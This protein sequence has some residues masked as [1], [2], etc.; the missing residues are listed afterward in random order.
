MSLK[1]DTNNMLEWEYE[2]LHYK[3]Y[4][5]MKKFYFD[6]ETTGLDPIKND[7]IQL[8]AIIEIDGQECDRFVIEM[9][10]FSYDNI[11][12]EALDTHGM[13]I[14]TIKTFQTCQEGY[15]KILSALDRYID[16]Y[17]KNDK[18]IVC[19]Y[20]VRFDIDFLNQF[21][22]KN[23]NDYLFS[24]FGAQQDPLPVFGYLKGNGQI[25][26]QNLKLVTMCQELGV[27]LE[28]A[29]DAM[30]DIDA[31]KRLIE[32]LNKRLIFKQNA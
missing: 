24:Y 30:A 18:F 19:G 26:P 21:F 16:K 23:G 8:A 27:S 15:K 6:T 1:K 5:P 22:Q 11:S 25:N 4:N 28:N 31:T 7:I 13:S 32:E 20:N 9:Q 12:Q 10:P 3:N 2:L 29:H 17:D 14:E